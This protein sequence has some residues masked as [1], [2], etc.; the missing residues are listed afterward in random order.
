MASI[1]E[2]GNAS[3]SSKNYNEYENLFNR[4]NNLNI[5]YRYTVCSPDDHLA[6]LIDNNNTQ[7]DSNTNFTNQS[8]SKFIDYDTV[9]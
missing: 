9:D 6:S 5:S 1:D 8:D 4:M 7:K 3:N 2:F